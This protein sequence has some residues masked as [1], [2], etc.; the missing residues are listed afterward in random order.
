MKPK[1]KNILILV[2]MFIIGFTVGM[3][4]TFHIVFKKI[5]ANELRLWM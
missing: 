5:W 2:F 3:T 4:M 1:I